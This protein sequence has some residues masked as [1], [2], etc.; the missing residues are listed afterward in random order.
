M[1]G[2]VELAQ[3]TPFL[4]VFHVAT[5]CV[6]T[7]SAVASDAAVSTSGNV[8][9]ASALTSSITNNVTAPNV[10]HPISHGLL[11]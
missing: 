7:M 8:A 4:H 9:P 10:V 6:M 11:W 1:L 3:R 5:P 2:I